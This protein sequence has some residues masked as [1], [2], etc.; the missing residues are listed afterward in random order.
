MIESVDSISVLL[1]DSQLFV[2]LR[3]T[4]LDLDILCD[5]AIKNEYF[6]SLLELRIA[7]FEE[8][9][10]VLIVLD[11]LDLWPLQIYLWELDDFLLAKSDTVVVQFDKAADQM[12]H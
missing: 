6:L 12:C 4:L 1:E 5:M 8:H 2:Q 7:K 3:N 9:L 10:S 11:L